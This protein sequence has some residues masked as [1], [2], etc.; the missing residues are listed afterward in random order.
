MTIF[1]YRKTQVAIAL[2]VG[3]L[4]VTLSVS[5][6]SAYSCVRGAY[7]AGC[8][9][10]RG[11]IAVGPRGAVAV[12]RYGNVYS[13]QRGSSCVWRNGQRVCL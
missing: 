3:L 5:E 7:R 11:A 9:G 4:G 6:A 8:I 2:A 12:G 1:S 10:P 13:Y